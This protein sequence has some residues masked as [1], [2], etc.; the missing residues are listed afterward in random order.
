M[1]IAQITDIHL[2][3]D[4]S[5]PA[6][7]NRRRL[8]KVLHR[9]CALR[10]LPDMLLATGDLTDKGDE[11]SYRLLREAL[12]PCPFPVHYGLGNHDHRANFARRFPETPREGGYVQYVIDD[13]RLRV[14]ML[15]T[16]GEGRH[17]GEF[18][19]TRAAWLRA[20]LAE[21]RA[22]PTLIV[23]HHPPIETGIGWMTTNP[24]AGWV[25]RLRA[26]MAEADNIVGMIAGH[27]HRP[28]MASWEG[29]MLAVAPPTAPQVALELSAIDPERPDGRPMII[30]DPPGF[31]LHWW[32]GSQL[33][34][35]F[36]NADDHVEI[37]RYD[38]GMQS[39]VRHLIA[40]KEGDS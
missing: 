39:L 35:H 30:A 29:R 10:P 26:A 28:I 31:A 13:A 34:T 17:G 8:D 33:V 14:I 27:I 6:E 12:E 38:A 24:E 2:G 21:E 18:C 7:L 23:L 37:A 22:A 36:D 25:A 3:F 4:P 9:I 32:N 16:L 20:R 5:D 1:L 15:D 19:A 40:E 11:R